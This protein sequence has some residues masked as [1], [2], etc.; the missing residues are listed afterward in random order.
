MSHA[1]IVRDLRPSP[2]HASSTSPP[3]DAPRDL[4]LR[5]IGFG[6]VG[7]AF[8]RLVAERGDLLARREGTR[9]R[10][11]AIATGGA[12]ARRDDLLRA[13]LAPDA[14]FDAAA[15]AAPCDVVVDASSGGVALRD[16]A[17]VALDAGVPFVTASKELVAEHGAELEARAVASG[18]AF[19]FEAA[20]AAGLPLF[21]RLGRDLRAVRLRRVRAILNGTT[22]VVLDVLAGDRG[23]TLVSALAVARER[24]LA[25]PD[26]SEDLSGRDAARK[27]A[28][29]AWRLAGAPF[30]V[31]RVVVEPLVS[32]DP[33]RLAH[34]ARSGLRVRHV[35]ELAFDAAGDPTTARVGLE[36]LPPEDPLASVADAENAVVLE[37]DLIPRLV[38]R[39]PGAGPVPT[40]SALLDDA[41]DAARIGGAR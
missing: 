36:A 2:A 34:A 27:L 32:V 11:V 10:I 40:A 7:A 12:N 19:R 26:A 25:E 38:L 6:R 20:V 24:G 4:R 5:L 15:P 28:I 23:A 41:L 16:A 1:S 33:E 17:C 21:R 8:A 31:A 39:G 14:T 30:P 9:P 35:A 3:R 37:G 13:S 22:N 18:S 29:L